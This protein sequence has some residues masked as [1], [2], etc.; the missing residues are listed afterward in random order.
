[1]ILHTHT[2][3]QIDT[4]VVYA[5]K[6]GIHSTDFFH[7]YLKSQVPIIIS[8]SNLQVTETNIGWPGLYAGSKDLVELTKVGTG[9][10]RQKATGTRDWNI[11]RTP[12]LRCSLHGYTHLSTHSLVQVIQQI[13]TEGL[14]CA[15]R[16]ENPH[17]GQTCSPLVLTDI[18]RLLCYRVSHMQK[19]M[20]S[21]LVPIPLQL[22]RGGR[23]PSETGYPG[24]T[25]WI[26]MLLSRQSQT[27]LQACCLILCTSLSLIP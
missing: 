27:F 1:M 23:P 13:L 20:C 14:F 25:L 12:F 11:D 9:D 22:W 5:Y 2:H 24:L 6:N 7:V 4:H 18:S 10:K 21:P 3:A 19:T 15:R 8:G 17:T 16:E 26:R